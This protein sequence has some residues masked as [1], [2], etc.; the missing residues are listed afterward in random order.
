MKKTKRVAYK[1]PPE[2]EKKKKH[3]E[4]DKKKKKHEEPE[5]EVMDPK[6]VT[7]YSNSPHAPVQG[8]ALYFVHEYK[9]NNVTLLHPVN[10]QQFHLSR[11]DFDTG[12]TEVLLPE[13]ARTSGASTCNVERLADGLIQKMKDY[14]ERRTQFPQQVVRK[15]VAYLK[16]IS[17]DKVP[18]FKELPFIPKPKVITPSLEVPSYKTRGRKILKQ[19]GYKDPKAKESRDSRESAISS[20]SPAKTQEKRGSGRDKEPGSWYLASSNRAIL[21]RALKTGKEFKTKELQEMIDSS[22]DGQLKG[23]QKDAKKLGYKFT[24]SGGPWQMKPLKKG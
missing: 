16:N 5:I 22:I 20:P 23:L 9:R 3:K 6:L 17:L 14:T 1:H 15:A 21:F 18:Q 13:E 2:P 7:C 11:R 10:L 19:W 8:R 24:K 12:I 4:K